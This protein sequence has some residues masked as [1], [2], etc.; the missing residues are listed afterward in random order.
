MIPDMYPADTQST[1]ERTLFTALETG[2]DDDFTVL[3]SVPW[4]DGAARY[5]Q[6]GECDFVV[7]HPRHGLLA[8]ETKSGDASYDAQRRTWYRPDG[9]S[10]NKDPFTQAQQS[11]HHMEKLLRRDVP[12]W[13]QANPPFGFAVAFPDADQ[14][15]GRF[16]THVHPDIV[17]LQSDLAK[18]QSR[19]P[20]ILERY[21]S[22]QVQMSSALFQRALDRLLPE[23]QVARSLRAQVRH[24]N[25]G[26]VR[27]TEEQSRYLEAARG[28]RRLLI[29]GCAGSGKTL[30]AFEKSLRLAESGSRVLLLCF[31][32][33]LANWLRDLARQHAP[34][35][36]V[37]VFH[38]HGL[39]E[40]VTRSTGRAFEVP[41]DA[42][43]QFWDIDCAAR[44]EKSL[45]EFPDRYDAIVVDEGQD[46]I[47]YWW[48]PIE[49]LLADR[50]SGRFYIFHDPQQNIFQR[51]NGFPFREPA[52]S[53]D[54]NCRNA[55]KIANYVHDVIGSS[56][57]SAGLHSEDIAPDERVIHSDDEERHVLAELV[58]RL[59]GRERLD[60]SQVTIIGRH[61]FENSPFAAG[62]EVAGIPIV[63]ET[64]PP[65]DRPVI[66]YATIYRFK[67]LET[68]CA[69]L[70]GFSH[71]D[72]DRSRREL[73][74]AASRA[75]ALLF[76]L[77]RE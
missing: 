10:L 59:V 4:L 75:K 55:P 21:R 39:C 26:L 74:V 65:T 3:H 69:I 71:G 47:D 76:V 63:S 70:S 12:G 77:L 53:L 5:L 15:L 33:P 9:T 45:P 62:L 35:G 32:I 56:A 11:S 20:S 34:A 73:Y 68:D 16:T 43:S 64:E 7:I 2:L 66:R 27:M 50:E 31:N 51:Q 23:F 22:P 37:D 44:L 18:L 57:R 58:E 41:V 1:A 17:I 30:L 29:D 8:I 38:F 13:S 48:I 54:L 60:P 36:R 42:G 67:G 19:I 61:R 72:D 25:Q 24:Q 6:Q 49:E 14:V 40:H 28:N 46:F 52:M